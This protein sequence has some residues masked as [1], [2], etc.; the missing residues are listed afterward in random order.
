MAWD[1]GLKFVFSLTPVLPQGGVCALRDKE[2]GSR[3]DVAR[4]LDQDGCPFLQ[5]QSLKVPDQRSG[6]N[7]FVI[8]FLLL[9]GCGA[10][11]GSLPSRVMR[12][13]EDAAG[14]IGFSHQP[15]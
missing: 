6:V 12:V 4:R 7:G 9:S 15:V 10:I 11:I 14:F 3:L 2:D 13:H 5:K 8:Y 1:C